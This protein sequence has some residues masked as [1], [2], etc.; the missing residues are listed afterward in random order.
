MTANKGVLSS[1]GKPVSAKQNLSSPRRRGRAILCQVLGFILVLSNVPSKV[2]GDALEDSARALARKVW[3]SLH[4][5]SVTCDFRNLS[6]LRRA[7]VASFSAA[8]REELQRRGVKIVAADAAVQLIVSITQAPAEYLGVVQIVRKENTETM[9]ETIGPVNAQ[10]APEAAFSLTLRREFLFSQESPILDV[11]IEPDA[12]RASVLGARGISGY[13]YRD[14]HWVLMRFER[15]PRHEVPER[16]ERG[17]FGFGIDTESVVFPK[18][19][20]TMSLL[21]DAKGWECQKNT[22]GFGIRGVTKEGMTGKNL[23]AWASAAQ[24]ESEGKT[25]IVVTGQDG[26]ARLYEDGPEPVAAFPDWGSEIASVY[27]GC[28]S[29]WQLLVT[30]KGDWTKPDEIQAID[31]QERRAQ[32]VSDPLEFSGPIVALHVASTTIGATANAN[33]QAIAVDRNLQTGRYEAYLL[34]IGCSR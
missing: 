23:K 3:S 25:R 13:E 14:E 20:C 28:G 17:F 9:M 26:L 29:G 15:L 33:T 22:W 18:E 32:S 31:I 2:R 8:F 6:S 7:E 12:K 34:S 27:S 1:C 30:G 11:F 21:P 4:D 24:L 19:V 10:A 5:T 16:I